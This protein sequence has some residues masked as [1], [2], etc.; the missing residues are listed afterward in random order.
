MR[1]LNSYLNYLILFLVIG[2]IG[3]YFFTKSDKS[4][5]RTHQEQ[6]VQKPNVDDVV[7]RYM[8]ETSSTNKRILANTNSA[9]RSELLKAKQKLA[10]MQDQDFSEIPLEKQIWKDGAS[11]EASSVN[12]EI[13][14]RIHSKEFQKAQEDAYKKEY[15]R[16]YIEN[17][18]QNGYII[19]LDENLNV[20]KATPI[21][22]PSDYDDSI[23]SFPTN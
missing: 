2:Y 21:R 3:F 8:Q 6:I 5:V 17:A 20:I 9:V 13:N 19:E 1:S 12:E 23:D 15:A 10:K 7:N 16:Q 4:A 14:Q 11:S 18:R 22:R